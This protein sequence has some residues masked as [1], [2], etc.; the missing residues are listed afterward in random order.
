MRFGLLLLLI[1]TPSLSVWGKVLIV[2]DEVPAMQLLAS[3]LKAAEAINS[4]IVQ[5]TDMPRDLSGYSSVIVYIHRKLAEEAEKLF[6]NYAESGGNLVLLHHSISSGKR[7]NRYW[8]PFLHISLPEGEFEQG[9]YRWTEGVSLEIVNLAPTEYITTHKVD[10]PKRI[11]Y[12]SSEKAGEPA[13]YPGFRLDNTEVY[14][15]HVFTGQRTILLGIKYTDAKTGKTYMQDRGGWY[16]P[17]GK[18]RVVYLMV[19]HSRRDFEDPAY[20]RIVVNAA[21][22]K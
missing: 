17:A 7:P 3:Q 20:S 21:T 13:V 2:C 16:M 14:L 5:Q 8:F 15:N 22:G 1:L 4:T 12:T 10:Y 9:G 19:G 11:A 18:G 6:I